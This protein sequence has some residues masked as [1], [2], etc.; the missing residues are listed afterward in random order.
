MADKQPPLQAEIVGELYEALRKVGA[1]SDLLT[2]VGS[3]GDTQDDQ[4][5]LEAL[6]KW[7]ASQPAE[8]IP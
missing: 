8:P 1:K 6:R 7:N 5:V 4:W 3:W 2:I